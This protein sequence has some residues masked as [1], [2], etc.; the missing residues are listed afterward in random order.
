MIWHQTLRPFNINVKGLCN[1]VMLAEPGAQFIEHWLETYSTFRSTGT[2]AFWSEHSVTIPY[3][4]SKEYPFLVTKLS[5]YTFH[6]PIYDEMG[7]SLL[8]EKDVFFKNAFVHHLWESMAWEK[9]L[10]DLSI[11]YIKTVD[12]TYNRIARKYLD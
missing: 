9:Y 5:P 6:Y 1:A 4:L 11:D 2:D 8:F 7:L 12:T 10:K 3:K